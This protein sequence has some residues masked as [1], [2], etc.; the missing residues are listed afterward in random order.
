VS[1]LP[2]VPVLRVLVD[3]TD[4]TG[5]TVFAATSVG[6]FRST[7]RGATWAP[8]NLGVLTTSPVYD[9]EQNHNGTIFIGTH[10][11]GAY[12]LAL[13]ATPTPTPAATPTPSAPIITSIPKVIQVG[14]SFTIQGAGF[15]PGSVVNFFVATAAGPINAGPLKPAA[16]PAPTQIMQDVPATVPLGEG[17]VAVQVVNTDQGYAASNLKYALLQGNPADDLPTIT[18]INGAGL[19]PLSSDPSYGLNVIDTVVRLGQPL[20]ITGTGFDTANGVAVDIFCACPGGK[21]GPFFMNPGNPGL[22]ST[23]LTLSIPASGPNAPQIGPGSI[24][25]SNAGSNHLYALKS[26]SVAVIIGAP[27]TISSVMQ[28]GCTV[29]V[30]GTGF[31]TLT[32]INLFNNQPGGVVNLGG[33][34]SD[35]S[36][37]IPLNFIS[38]THFTFMVPSGAVSGPAYLQAFNPP[39][40]PFTSSGNSPNGAFTIVTP[41][42]P[43]ATP[44]TAMTPTPVVVRTPTPTPIP[45]QTPT[46]VASRTPTPVPTSTPGASRTPLTP[47]P[48]PSGAPTPTVMD[49]PVPQVL[50]IYH[51]AT[52]LADGT[53]L[54]AGGYGSCDQ[55]TYGTLA[56]AEIYNPVGN[57]VTEL[58]NT[59]AEARS[60]ATAT[61]LNDGTVLIV[62]GQGAFFP[63]QTG[64]IYDPV[65]Q[66]FTLTKGTLHDLH[67]FATATLLTSGPN[68]GDV[69][70][71][72]GRSSTAELYDPVKQTF[73]VTSQPMTTSREHAVAALI[74]SGLYAGD[75]LIAG[76]DDGTNALA[77]TEIYDPAKDTFTAAGTMGTARDYLAAALLSNGSSVLFAGGSASVGQQGNLVGGLAALGSAELS[78][79]NTTSTTGSM[80]AARENHSAVLF[81]SGPL[82]DKV[83]ITGGDTGNTASPTILG[84]EEL[85][86]PMSKTF[87]PTAALHFPRRYHTATVLNDGRVLIVDGE[88]V[89]GKELNNIEL[90]VP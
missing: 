72:G 66:T 25:V 13:G 7:N 23:T 16:P 90:F 38:S 87:S 8:F 51:T 10:G 14:G 45:T 32:V 48:T 29:E 41:C 56:C 64:E 3:R 80:N 6:V 65:S 35:G 53:V 20:T 5:S 37:K 74:T 15:T 59:M 4:I 9:I 79:V 46:S 40:V 62:G 22:T 21:V 26:N 31:S 36:A 85:Y 50:R 88:T 34:N 19:S 81:S 1:P 61:L 47:T 42:A 24:Q 18:E 70:I 67:M 86:D 58:S 73:T 77:S 33:L 83:L 76:G 28:T 49:G 68:A 39:F 2:D 69:L 12:R 82:K 43:T 44:T 11:R 30:A 89:G 60:G 55:M 75:V 57:T 27:I 17:F 71:A 78:M 63:S 54:I 84:S 52:L